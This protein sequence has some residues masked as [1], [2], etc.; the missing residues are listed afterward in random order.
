MMDEN[1]TW[2]I[3]WTGPISRAFGP[4]PA[5]RPS[6]RPNWRIEPRLLN[7]SSTAAVSFPISGKVTG[8]VS[9]TWSSPANFVRCARARC[10]IRLTF[11]GVRWACGFVGFGIFRSSATARIDRR[12]D[13]T[14][15]VGAWSR[16]PATS[17]LFTLHLEAASLFLSAVRPALGSSWSPLVTGLLSRQN[18]L[19]ILVWIRFLIFVVGKEGSLSLPGWIILITGSSTTSLFVGKAQSSL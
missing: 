8:T 4:R 13:W 3:H 5:S 16:E 7:L 9:G 11:G 17:F 19:S 18:R 14:I 1:Q 6:T 2:V 12:P 15:F 10:L